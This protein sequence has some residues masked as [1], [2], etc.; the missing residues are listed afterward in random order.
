MTGVTL[1]RARAA[2]Q[3]L[4]KMISPL[5]ELRGI[6]IAILANGYGVKVNL[7][8]WPACEIPEE[9]DQVPVIVEVT[10]TIRP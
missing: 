1:E 9:I 8:R 4:S 5:P 3:K 6:G 7:A 2:K 10:G